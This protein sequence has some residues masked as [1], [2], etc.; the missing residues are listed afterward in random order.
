MSEQVV[1][2][3]QPFLM[4]LMTLYL[5]AKDPYTT[6]KWYVDIFG[7][8]PNASHHSPLQEGAGL[9]VLH[10]ASDLTLFFVRS[11]DKLPLSFNNDEG[12]NHAVLLF[13]VKDAEIEEL[14]ARL[15][16]HGVPLATEEI[17]DRGGCG[18]ELAFYDPD[19]RKIEI[20]T[21]DT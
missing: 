9:V 11:E 3:K 10:T 21:F 12:H 1:E 20:N 13:R 19:G 6:A 8:D 4:D 14:Y 16:E 2:K 15:I 7:F 17:V 5:P 18:R